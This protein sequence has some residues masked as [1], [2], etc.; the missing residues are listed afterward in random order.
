MPQLVQL[1]EFPFQR[2]EDID[3]NVTVINKEPSRY[4]ITFRVMRRNSYFFQCMPDF[5]PD[6]FNLPAALPGA[7]YKVISEAA[8]SPSI[9]QDDVSGLF[10]TS[11]FYN[12]SRYFYRL[13]K[14]P[15][16]YLR[17]LLFDIPV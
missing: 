8:Y 9:Q 15:P 5:I 10:V 4:R 7:N 17:P 11:R 6:G 16:P 12:L 3:D 13:Q 1:V 2:G 14:L